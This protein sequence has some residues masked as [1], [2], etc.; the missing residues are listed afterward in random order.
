MSLATIALGS[1]I[2]ACSGGGSSG[3]ITASTS[4]STSYQAGVTFGDN[5]SLCLN[6]NTTAVPQTAD[7][8]ALNAL[9]YS[10][11]IQNSSYGLDGKTITGAITAKEDGSYG[12]VGSTNGTIFVYP[13]YALMVIK[14]EYDNPAYTNYFDKNPYIQQDIYVPIFALV[15]SSLLTT[16][17]AITS[18]G[19]SMEFRSASMGRVGAGSNAPT[20]TSEASRG[21]ITKISATSFSVASCS[22]NGSSAQNTN[23]TDTNCA[24]GPVTTKTYNYDAASGSWLVTPVDAPNQVLRAYFVADVM[25]NSVVGY[26]DT[27]DSSMDTS[28]FAVATVVPAN[29]LQ[30]EFGSGSLTFTSY[31]ACSS[32]ENC[33]GNSGDLG[34]DRNTNAV[35][36]NSGTTFQSTGMSDG[37]C[38]YIVRPNGVVNG[39]M[40]AVYTGGPG[41]CT[42]SGSRPDNMMFFFGSRITNNGK[43]VTLSV[44][45]G[46]DPTVTVGPSQ[47]ISINYIVQN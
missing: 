41:A 18:N 4:T 17:D 28:K 30:P 15:K 23:L 43:S 46:Y 32:R 40:D 36:P 37:P 38:D 26:V 34:V 2:V 5:G 35:I 14:L 10:L 45:A 24:S 42:S 39:Y 8:P 1:I 31:Q 27:A 11:T 47:K 29:T 21:T 33:A 44:M 7:C 20:Y 22:N 16:V 6:T 12:I 13:S 25:T 3:A 19:A 9:S